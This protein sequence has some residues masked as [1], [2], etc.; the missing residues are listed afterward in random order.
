MFLFSSLVQFH[1]MPLAGHSQSYALGLLG[2]FPEDH[3]VL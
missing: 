2:S 1:T 3:N